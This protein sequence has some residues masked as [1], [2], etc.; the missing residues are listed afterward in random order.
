MATEKQIR[1]AIKAMDA[2]RDAL[3][4]I[5]VDDP[6]D[7]V[8]RLRR[9]LSEYADYLEKATWWRKDKAA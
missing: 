6:R 8:S 1:K 7:S 9:D 3:N 4:A 2:A 5:T